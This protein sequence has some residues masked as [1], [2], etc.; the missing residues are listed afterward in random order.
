MCAYV[1][2]VL[3]KWLRMAKVPGP[4]PG[5]AVVLVVEDNGLI[6][7]QLEAS[8]RGLGA[9]QVILAASNP[10]ALGAMAAEALSVAIL[11]VDLGGQ[12]S[13]PVALALRERGVP[14]IVAT[15]FHS[16]EPRDPAFGD[17]PFASKPFDEIELAR[18]LR[19]A[20]VAHRAS[21]RA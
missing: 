14:F 16:D 13:A 4:I 15:G 17:A 5:L 11:D 21:N 12:S 19:E 9:G 2:R 1:Q 20:L 7:L 6:A 3:C 10:E 18:S 8:L